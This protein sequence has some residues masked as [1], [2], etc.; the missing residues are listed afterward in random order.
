MRK[1]SAN[2]I[3]PVNSPSLKNGIISIDDIG[4]IIEITNTKGQLRELSRMEFY[5]GVIIP[6][7]VNI[8]EIKLKNSEFPDISFNELLKKIIDEKS[9]KNEQNY[10][11]IEVGKNPGL[12]LIINFDF[13]FMNICLNSKI[14]SISD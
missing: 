14:Q 11:Y 5:N 9:L 2:Y 7:C 1:I 3:F 13:D 10:S 4:T 12:N 8:D 6:G